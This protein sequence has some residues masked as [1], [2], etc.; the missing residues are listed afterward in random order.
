MRKSYFHIGSV[1]CATALSN[2][3]EEVSECWWHELPARGDAVQSSCIIHVANCPYFVKHS[4]DKGGIIHQ[5]ACSQT[6]NPYMAIFPQRPRLVL[7]GM[8][9]PHAVLCVPLSFAV[10]LSGAGWEALFTAVG[11]SRAMRHLKWVWGVDW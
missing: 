8:L 10:D 9:C 3:F 1:V 11:E 7:S 4:R 2:L 5:A 6:L